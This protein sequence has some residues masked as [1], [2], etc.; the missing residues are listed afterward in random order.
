M[1]FLQQ[2]LGEQDE[3]LEKVGGSVHILKHMSHRIGD[4]LEEQAM[5]AFLSSLAHW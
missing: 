5:Y 1:Y 4:E 2:I 3:D